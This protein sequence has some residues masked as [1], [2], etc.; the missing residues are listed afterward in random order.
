MEISNFIAGL[1]FALAS[2]LWFL[3]LGL[4]KY[5]L[6]LQLVAVAA[7][8]INKGFAWMAGSLTSSG[9]LLLV[10][11]VAFVVAFR[12]FL[13]GS[14]HKL[15]SLALV[16]ILPV[17]TMWTLADIIN[18]NPQPAG[19]TTVPVGTPAWLALQG[20]STVDEI[21]GSIASGFGSFAPSAINTPPPTTLNC[22]S[23][24]DALYGEY[25]AFSSSAVQNDTS[26]EPFNAAAW[27]QAQTT[28][29]GLQFA[30]ASNVALIASSE[31]WQQAYLSDWISA[32]YGSPSQGQ[33]TY[34][35]Q[36]EINSG[37][38]PFEQTALTQASSVYNS[39]GAN[40]TPPI[41]SNVFYLPPSASNA[42]TLATIFAF[43]AC[44][45][46]PS[47]GNFTAANDWKYFDSS[48]SKDANTDC[49]EFFNSASAQNQVSS[50][51]QSGGGGSGTTGDIVHGTESVVKGGCS[52]VSSV[53]TLGFSNNVGGACSAADGVIPVVSGAFNITNNILNRVVKLTHGG[54]GNTVATCD[55][56]IPFLANLS[57]TT[58]LN[59]A[60]IYATTAAPSDSVTQNQLSQNYEAVKSYWGQNESFAVLDSLLALVTAVAYIYAL[61]ALALGAIL[62]QVG[63]VIML[64]LLPATLLLLAIPSKE[65]GRIRSG[66]TLLRTTLGFIVSKAVL[67]IVLVIMLEMILWIQNLIPAGSGALQGI[68]HAMIPLAVLYLVRKLLSAMGMPNLTSIQGAL[69]M[70][71]AA[72]MAMSGS[73]NATNAVMGGLNKALGSDAIRDKDGNIIKKAKGINRLDAASKRPLARAK[74]G[75]RNALT[76]ARDGAVGFLGLD[77][78]R[79]NIFGRRDE[80]GNLT[81]LGHRQRL[82][83]LA[84]LID[85][86]QKGRLSGPV[87]DKLLGT[88]AGKHFDAFAQNR[89]KRKGVGS[90]QV[91]LAQIAERDHLREATKYKTREQRLRILKEMGVSANNEIVTNQRALRNGSNEIIYDPK[92]GLPVFAYRQGYEDP[93]LIPK[94]NRT[95]TIDPRTGAILS[96]GQGLPVYALMKKNADGTMEN[97]DFRGYRSMHRVD[98][99]SVSAL[100]QSPAVLLSYE[101]AQR[102]SPEERAKLV[103]ETELA[104]VLNFDSVVRNGQDFLDSHGM[105]DGQVLM[106]LMGH[107]AII[108]PK[109]ADANGRNRL[110]VTKNLEGDRFASQYAINY[111]PNE[112]KQR[113]AGFTDTEYAVYQHLQMYENGGYD[114]DGN[115]TNFPM[116][117]GININTEYGLAELEAAKAGMPSAFDKIQISQSPE[118]HRAIV[119]AARDIAKGYSGADLRREVKIVN[120]E[121]ARSNTNVAQINKGV[122]TSTTAS[123]DG[124]MEHL[125]R[126]SMRSNGVRED[127]TKS[128][129][130]EVSLRDYLAE[131]VRL[132]TQRD[133][134]GSDSDPVVAAEIDDLI[135]KLEK[136]IRS[137]SD[138]ASKRPEY[139]ARLLE[140]DKEIEGHANSLIGKAQGTVDPLASIFEASEDL[141]Y[142]F[143]IGQAARGKKGRLGTTDVA[144]I[145]DKKDVAAMIR[146]GNV[147]ARQA[148][149]DELTATLKRLV[150]DSNSDV[151]AR[152][153]AA[154]QLKRA[155]SQLTNEASKVADDAIGMSNAAIEAG[156]A[157][158]E[159]PPAEKNRRVRF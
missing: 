114:A 58:Y 125:S 115:V 136:N 50:T 12:M 138:I 146:A 110:L 67:T 112:I 134:L 27:T 121:T 77:E 25:T 35:R 71:T 42:D 37:I 88:S 144:E 44:T 13:K 8:T 140:L 43:D 89:D 142:Q 16:V 19:S 100:T 95:M 86:A 135:T 104:N 76:G 157:A 98:P 33:N 81:Q 1:F 127:L 150:N 137:T 15:F 96:N 85:I 53:L 40:A 129:A 78:M 60:Y 79:T 48:G 93:M 31:L 87:I 124:V 54:C 103:P 82:N 20:T 45:Y 3:L 26:S 62:A 99:N 131:Q 84:G 141:S 109:L 17:A 64:L 153:D 123:M 145:I 69:S 5:A 91:A 29:S 52:F 151:Y 80:N 132:T 56:T 107:D 51:A 6:D 152:R 105:R 149:I 2:L 106:S 24:V 155:V 156:N 83:S 10:L 55:G 102:L 147:R 21:A 23:Y 63:L 61:G 113:P 111:L 34:C 74:K 97:I 128:L 57:T 94:T 73:A 49:N 65:G 116:A 22:A 117:Y 41:S 4:I 36:L 139:E 66:T 92:T 28:N 18:S 7:N 126:A 59:E 11:G 119:A 90:Y 75:A 130:A 101:E 133:N 14:V 122:L 148:Q 118:K 38:S 30:P 47:S 143:E 70:P 68:V 120:A 154:E 108:N 158:L 159:E 9:A 72:A 39:Q 32:Q 46:D